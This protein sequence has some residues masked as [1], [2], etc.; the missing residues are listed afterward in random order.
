MDRHLGQLLSQDGEAMRRAPTKSGGFTLIEIMVSITI[1]AIGILV[2]GGLLLRSSKTAE[3]AS[4]ASYQTALMAKEVS[5]YDAL[6]FD[7]L[8][9]GN[10]CTTTAT[11]PLPN[12]L[13]VTIA[14]VSAKVK[15]V[16]ILLQPTDT[17]ISADSTMFER[18]KSGFG[19][20]LNTP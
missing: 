17:R 3:A 2:L 11:H 14:T 20:P 8:V 6:P 9:D 18:S 19:N 10:T 4:S 5:Y 16:K 13:C 15:S 1:L 12:T 7:Q